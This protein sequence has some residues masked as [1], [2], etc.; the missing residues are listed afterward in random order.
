MADNTSSRR[1]FLKLAQRI[2]VLA[3]LGALLAPIIA[4]FYPKDLQETPSEPVPV[5]PSAP[6]T[7][8]TSTPRTGA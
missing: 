4:Y 5:G 8:A 2:G 1:G 7:R 3:G 6:A